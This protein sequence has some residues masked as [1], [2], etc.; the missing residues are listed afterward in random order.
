MKVILSLTGIISIYFRIVLLLSDFF[1]LLKDRNQKTR[2]MFRYYFQIYENGVVSRNISSHVGQCPDGFRSGSYLMAFWMA[3]DI[4]K[5]GLVFYRQEIQG[6]PNQRNSID[7]DAL[8]D[9]IKRGAQEIKHHDF[10]TDKY[11]KNTLTGKDIESVIV[12]T[13]HKI[14]QPYS[15]F[16][17]V[18]HTQL[19]NKFL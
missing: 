7:F 14:A 15:I 1:Y 9:E 18:S 17:N 5:D 6:K 16:A 4:R 8:A 10:Y 2:K 19:L 12:I 11:K 3:T 13:W